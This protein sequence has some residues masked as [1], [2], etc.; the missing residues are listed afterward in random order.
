[1][2]NVL[3]A[4]IIVLLAKMENIILKQLIDVKSVAKIVY[5]AHH[6]LNVI[7]ARYNILRKKENVL[8]KKNLCNV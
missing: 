3:L 7:N 6:Q 2:E 5:Y 4:L 1:M 8:I